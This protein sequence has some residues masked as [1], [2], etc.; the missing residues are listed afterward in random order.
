VEVELPAWR[1]H[2]DAEADPA[3]PNE[4]RI[5]F[6]KGAATVSVLRIWD[7]P[8]S[9]GSPMVVQARRDVFVGG[10]ATE[11]VTTSFFEGSAKEVRAFWLKGRGY[12][13][14]YT[15]RVVLE[16][17]ADGVVAEVLRGIRVLW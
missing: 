3:F 16:G 7:L 12:D 10:R 4:R 9:P 13:V 8:R 17:C 11:L 6:H 5:S 2:E 14:E 15:V 1:R